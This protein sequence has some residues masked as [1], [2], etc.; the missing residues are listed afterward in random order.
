[1]I[2]QIVTLSCPIRV[3]MKIVKLTVTVKS[4]RV[5]ELEMKTM[6]LSILFL[7]TKLLKL[8]KKLKL[9]VSKKNKNKNKEVT[10][11]IRPISKR[12]YSRIFGMI[13]N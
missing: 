3:S 12:S 10:R 9:L 8:L 5:I 11:K 7:E 2:L 1:M 4:E 13:L 6:M